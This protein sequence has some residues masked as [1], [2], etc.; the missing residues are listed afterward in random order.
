M[1]SPDCISWVLC[2]IMTESLRCVLP[3]FSLDTTKR[4]GQNIP[5]NDGC[6]RHEHI[7][8]LFNHLCSFFYWAGW[9]EWPSN[10]EKCGSDQHKMCSVHSWH[11]KGLSHVF[12]TTQGWSLILNYPL[13]SPQS[14]SSFHCWETTSGSGMDHVRR[15][16]LPTLHLWDPPLLSYFSFSHGF[17]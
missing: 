10:M 8:I 16:L 3:K 12:F 2:T 15:M 14:Q 1:T 9:S 13:C 5:R 11:G 17:L 7:T 4:R 6:R